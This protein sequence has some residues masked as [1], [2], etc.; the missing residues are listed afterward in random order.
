MEKC[1]DRPK[2]IKRRPAQRA[3]RLFSSSRQKREN[4]D[5][6][7]T[8]QVP[9]LPDGTIISDD[10]YEQMLQA[11]R[12]VR[13]ALAEVGGQLSDILTFRI[14]VTDMADY[15]AI[16]RAY[17]EMMTFAPLPTRTCVQVAGLVPGYKVE[18]EALCS[19]PE[20]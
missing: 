7:F 15:G 18:V 16:N 12:N 1:S 3:G 5:L 19:V 11:L 13:A 14:Y 10:A 4:R 17:G 6:F 20:R 8:T 9:T 2:R